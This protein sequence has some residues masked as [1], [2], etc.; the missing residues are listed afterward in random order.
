MEA[1]QAQ[2]GLPGSLEDESPTTARHL[3]RPRTGAQDSAAE[4]DAG[5]RHK[6]PSREGAH[7]DG[8]LDDNI[9]STFHSDHDLSQTAQEY[10]VDDIY[11]APVDTNAGETKKAGDREAKNQ[12][13]GRSNIKTTYTW[14]NRIPVYFRPANRGRSNVG[15]AYTWYNLTVADFQ[16]AKKQRLDRIAR[17]SA[18]PVSRSADGNMK[19]YRL[20]MG[21]ES[22][23]TSSRT[24]SSDAEAFISRVT[25]TIQVKEGGTDHTTGGSSIGTPI[26]HRLQGIGPDVSGSAWSGR[27]RRRAAIRRRS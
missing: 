24:D 6:L 19:L 23:E 4:H 21:S 14:D 3:K 20:V 2:Q 10:E 13:S 11:S 1:G 16:A 22:V 7:F 18:G 9:R 17:E 8:A 15:T 12:T 27:L 25:E 26:G 5:A